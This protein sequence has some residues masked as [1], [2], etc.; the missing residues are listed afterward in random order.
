MN[1]IKSF[2][3]ALVAIAVM[4]VMAQKSIPLVYDQEFTGAGYPAPQF[5]TVE[6][7]VVSET[8]TN[9][10]EFSNSNVQLKEFKDWERRRAEIVHELRSFTSTNI[11]KS[12]RNRWSTRKILRPSWKIVP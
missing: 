4:P 12:A 6:E 8:L 1:S 9:P 11:M 5:P 7:A 10:F 2:M 3:L